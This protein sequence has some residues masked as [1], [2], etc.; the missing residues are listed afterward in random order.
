MTP[1]AAAQPTDGSLGDRAYES[2]LPRFPASLETCWTRGADQTTSA[3][4]A[5]TAR[6]RIALGAGGAPGDDGLAARSG[7]VS[8][9]ADETGSPRARMAPQ[10]VQPVAMTSSPP[11]SGK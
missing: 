8:T 10:A 11:T 9:V 1:N 4:I 5:E 3:T 2:K 7:A 6:A